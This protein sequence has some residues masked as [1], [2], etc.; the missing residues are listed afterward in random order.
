VRERGEGG[1]RAEESR[2]NIRA[3]SRRGPC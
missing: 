3:S 1:G 2:R